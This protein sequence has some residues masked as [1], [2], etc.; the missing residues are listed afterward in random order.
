MQLMTDSNFKVIFR[1]P[2]VDT[3]DI[4]VRDL[5][6]AL[7][8]LGDVFQSASDT[9][10]GD[11][12]KTA[13][14]VKAT[15]AACFQ[16]DLSVVQSIGETLHSLLSLAAANKDGISAAKEL[17]D[18]ILKTGTAVGVVGGGLFAL[19][20]FLKGR[21]PEKIDD[22]GGAVHLHLDGNVFITNRKTI[23][24]AENV[25][26]RESAKRFVS[27]LKNAGIESISTKAE[28]D[29]EETYTKSD[30][31][32]FDLPNVI[33]EE[34]LDETRRM[35]LQIVSLSFKDDNK[36]RVT[37]GSE[38]FSVGIEDSDFLKQVA[39]SE[40]SFSRGD[41]LVCDVREKQTSTPQ[42]LKKSGL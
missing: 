11:R 17:A 3:G 18:L 4:D 2:A 7:L 25:G 35:N 12:V 5:A 15:E 27:V 36:W 14:R 42:G 34:L 16:V 26:V 23:I 40:I 21:K 9:L 37:D 39:N 19:L 10:N 28:G 31:I 22:V 1:G 6:P 30:L 41:Y 13:V 20:K 8:A 33:E 29:T 38:P 24:L 32:A